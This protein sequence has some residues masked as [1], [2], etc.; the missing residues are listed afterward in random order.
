LVPH[1]CLDRLC[2]D[3]AR[4]ERRTPVFP[5]SWGNPC[6]ID[7]VVSK[8]LTVP[9][10]K[11]REN[12]GG[13]MDRPLLD[14][15]S[16]K[17]PIVSFKPAS[18]LATIALLSLGCGGAKTPVPS[19]PDHSAAVTPS[20]PASA[21]PAPTNVSISTDILGKCGI[22]DVD[23]YFAFDSAR[24]TSNDRTPLDK[25]VQCFT[26]GPLAGRTVKLIGRADPRGPSEY[27][28]ALGESR[29]DAV[30]SYLDTRGLAKGKAQTTS[31]GALDAQGTDETGWQH[32]RRVDVL[33]GD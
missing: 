17:R 21:T 24:L 20:A 32:D 30:A 15:W 33:L 5:E 19:S 7:P 18:A 9:V 22:P 10:P 31:R 29:A 16:M 8:R 3:E 26:Q 2:E 12:T 4:R 1:G 14:N 25:L 28:M 11:L 13:A 23:A 27:N 6:C